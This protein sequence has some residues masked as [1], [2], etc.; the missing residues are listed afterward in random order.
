MGTRVDY[1]KAHSEA[2]GHSRYGRTYKKPLCEGFGERKIHL[3]GHSHGGQVIRL[4]T[5]LLTYGSET[6]MATTDPEDISPLFTG[7]KESYIESV[8]CICAP[9]NGSTIYQVVDDK[10]L[11]HTLGRFTDF[12]MGLLGRTPLHVRLVDYQF[13]QFG[14]TPVKG[15]F[16][17]DKLFS[18]MNRIRDGEDYVLSDLSLR[19]AYELNKLIEI[20]KNIHY[21]SY[22]ANGCSGEKHKSKNMNFPLLKIFSHV[23]V[24]LPLPADDFGLTFDESWRANDG[25]VNTVSAKNPA[26]EPAREFDG[27]A[28]KGVWNVMPVLQC[29]HG[30]ATGLFASRK[31]TRNFYRELGDMLIKVEN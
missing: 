7:G 16:K 27:T 29:D 10:N 22:A 30:M 15:E 3:I 5:H 24:K 13:E 25:L 20:S 12:M 31:K 18:A 6:E 9:N 14:L 8:T 11:V 2:H 17:Q 1:G 19:G 4:L 23:L 21:F 26:D 28:E